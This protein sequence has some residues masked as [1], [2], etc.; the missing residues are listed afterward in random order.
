MTRR[1]LLVHTGGTLGMRG[2]RPDALHP[3]PFFNTLVERVPELGSLAQVELDLFSNLDSAELQPESWVKL[4]QHL[5]TRMRAFDGVVITH[6]TDTLAYTAAALSFMLGRVRVPVVITGAQRPLGEVRSDARLNLIDA[7]TTALHG[8]R[9]VVVCFDSKVFRGNRVVKRSVGEYDA[10]ESPNAPPLGTL[11]VD[12]RF[13]HHPPPNLPRRVRAELDPRVFLFKLFPGFDPR[14]AAAVLPRVRGVVLEA[15]GSGTMTVEPASGRSMVPFFEAAQRR[16]LP[17]VIVSQA[18]HS[19]VDLGL[20]ESGRV[21]LR[22][23]V[24]SGGDMTAP[25][26]VTKLMH[27]LKVAPSPRAL[28]TYIER[29]VAGERSRETKRSLPGV[30]RHP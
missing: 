16:Q 6:G 11:G 7:V 20:Y 13:S 10:F 25:A 26:A 22:Y 21:A 5:H 23:G 15:Y 8:P 2:R 9:E 14:A 4:A 3:G 29:N 1:V 19:G 12:A 24:I 27:G 28:R 17:I 30:G 18:R